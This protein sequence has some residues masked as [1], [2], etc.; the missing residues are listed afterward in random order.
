MS[1]ALG[2][3]TN[4]D[5]SAVTELPSERKLQNSARSP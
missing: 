1:C 5:V 3:Q 4:S 2:L